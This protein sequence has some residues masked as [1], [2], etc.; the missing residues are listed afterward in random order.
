MQRHGISRL[1]EI[2]GDRPERQK[3]KRSPIGFFHIGSAEVQ[4]AQGKL[5]LFVGLD[6]TGKFAGPRLVDKT[7]RNANLPGG[8]LVIYMPATV[9]QH[10][11]D[12]GV[13]PLGRLLRNRLPGNA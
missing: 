2:D 8:A 4:T 6:R 11:G 1:P 3:V 12:H 13:S 9:V 10:S 5:Y 7:D